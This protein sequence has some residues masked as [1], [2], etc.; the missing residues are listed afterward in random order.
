MKLLLAH[1]GLL[2]ALLMPLVSPAQVPQSPDTDCYL[3]VGDSD[4]RVTVEILSLS[5]GSFRIS[6]SNVGTQVL[7]VPA[8]NGLFFHLT[9]R[10]RA[11]KE[12]I[13][14]FVNV[15]G[16]SD[17]WEL[18]HL[19]TLEITAL[20]PRESITYFESGDGQDEDLARQYVHAL[21]IEIG[22]QI[23]KGGD[24]PAR[25]LH[26]EFLRDQRQFTIIQNGTNETEGD[27]DVGP[28]GNPDVK[29]PQ[30]LG[31]YGTLGLWKRE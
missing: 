5:K 28:G 24:P 20:H 21:W 11:P 10:E 2:L 13:S 29:F 30:T 12:R 16:G 17:V 6:L 9:A 7:L 25:I 22:Y 19:D 23:H 8:G 27:P 15:S 18:R 3:L 1:I 4:L 26:S 14:L 31:Y